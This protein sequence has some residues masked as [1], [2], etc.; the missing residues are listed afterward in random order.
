VLLTSGYFVHTVDTYSRKFTPLHTP[1][2]LTIVAFHF[3]VFYQLK[4]K[5]KQILLK[6]TTEG[7]LRAKQKR[8]EEE[9]LREKQEE[10]RR[11]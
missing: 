4:E 2:S 9:A 7:K 1:E 6:T 3:C 5:K 11:A 8:A 10:K